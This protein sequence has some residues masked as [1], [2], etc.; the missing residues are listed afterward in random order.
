MLV[1]IC[2]Y[3]YQLFTKKE[4]F[5]IVWI[6]LDW[7]ALFRFDKIVGKINQINKMHNASFSPHQSICLVKVNVKNNNDNNSN[8]K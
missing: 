7:N 2:K 3:F 4:S 5:Q 8:N 6:G 1:S